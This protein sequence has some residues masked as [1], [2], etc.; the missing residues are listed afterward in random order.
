[1]NNGEC[2]EKIDVYSFVVLVY[3]IIS[4]G[5]LPDTSFSELFQG[6]T[7]QVPPSFSPNTKEIIE[8]CCNIN[9]H[10]RPSFSEIVDYLKNEKCISNDFIKI[11]TYWS[12]K[13]H[14]RTPKANFN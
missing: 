7:P 5:Q 14:Q 6:K 3:F 2:D 13:S 4:G 11:R 1:M 8:F 10:V 12:S 9:P